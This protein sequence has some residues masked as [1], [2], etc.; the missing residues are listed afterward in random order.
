MSNITLHVELGQDT[1]LTT[2]ATRIQATNTRELGRYGGRIDVN[3]CLELRNRPLNNFFSV[4]LIDNLTN[5][6]AIGEYEYIIQ[7]NFEKLYE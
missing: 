7:L 4:K 5:T 2:S 3:Q 1:S 6:V